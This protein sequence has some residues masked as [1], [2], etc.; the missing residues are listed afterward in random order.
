M[1][2][3]PM[4]NFGNL[5]P[6][7]QAGR[8]L[9][10]GAGHIAQAIN[11]IGQIGQQVSAT[12]LNEAQKIQ[13]E[14]DE[15]FF[16][17]QAA[18]YGSDYTDVVTDTKNKLITGELNE[19]TAKAYLRKKSDELSETYRQTLP[20]IKHDKFNYYTE[21]MYFDSE[22]NVK[23]LAYEVEKR[24]IN[25]DF[26][27]VGEATLKIEN[28][29]QALALI[30]NTIERNPVLT[31][32]QRTK[33][34]E[35]WNQRRDL[36]DG[37]GV[38][39]ALENKAD[40]EGLTK[41]RDDVDRIFPHMK[42]ETRD[43][44]KAQIDSAIDR[45]NKANEIAQTKVNNEAKQLANDLRTDAYTGYPISAERTDAVLAKVTGTEYEA[46]VR[47]DLALNKDAQKFR[48]LSPLEQERT[49][50]NLTT[51]LE[52]TPQSDASLLQKQLSMYQGISNAS[53]TRANN[54]PVGQIQSQT[55]TKLYTVTPEQIGT[56][57]IDFKQAQITTQ[58]LLDQ[59]TKNGGVGSLIQWN[60]TERKAFGDRYHDASP[61]KQRAML[62]DLTNMAGDSKE[63]QKEY[64]SLIA[65]EKNAYDYVGIANLNKMGI[66]LNGTNIQAADVALEGKE[67]INRQQDKLLANEQVFYNQIQSEFGNAVAS[68]SNEHS[69]YGHMAYSIYIGLAKRDPSLIKVDENSKPLINKD[70]AKR[71]FNIATGG[72]YKQSFGKNTNSVF[73]P[74]GYSQES[75]RDY[76]EDHFRTTFRKETGI[77]YDMSGV[78]DDYAIRRKQGYNHLFEFVQPNGKVFKN[79]KTGKDYFIAIPP[80][81]I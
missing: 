52:N 73:M 10:T 70:L 59:K 76:L 41:V 6:Q 7:A 32:E 25:A 64:F 39:N 46:Q 61:Q 2:Q 57:N 45:I 20:N 33:S 8:V 50:S 43:A 77:V 1:A 29:E 28:R 3:I 16:N 53:K 15:Y 34:L 47:E 54:D 12:K 79:P 30:R 62:T 56:G 19:G 80:K 22:A 65:G 75:F 37:K 40:V 35:E 4:G 68:G 58:M 72:T 81:Q 27:Q 13:D 44:Y 36:S 42:V 55:G 17:T 26:E 31:P 24:A 66:R 21:K 11:N 38:L 71:A 18:K 60:T 14:K 78:I 23:P 5:M 69:A 51:Q 48:K 49:I 9:D 63:A 74:Y 67:S